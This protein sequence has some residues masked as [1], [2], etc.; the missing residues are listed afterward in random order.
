MEIIDKPSARIIAEILSAH[1]VKTVVCSPGSR[2]VPLLDAVEKCP[3][4]KARVVIDERSAA[5]VALG[6]AATSQEPVALMCTSG[7]ALLNYA[8]AVAEAYYRHIPLIV[9]SA[10]RPQEWIDQDDSQTLRQYEALSNITKKSYDIPEDF[11]KP[12][13][14]GYVNRMVNDAMITAL[15][16]PHG[17]V[18]INVQFDAPLNSMTCSPLPPE[19]TRIIRGSYP[20]NHLP[21]DN[22]KEYA[23]ECK[24]K[25][26]MLVCGFLPPDHKLTEGVTALSRCP[27][28]TVMAETISNL[29]IAPENFMV[30]S[31]LSILTEEEK[32]RLHPDIVITLG[33]ALISRFLKD[34]LRKYKPGENWYV[35]RQATTADCFLSL[36]RR[37]ECNPTWFLKR[38]AGK[39]RNNEGVYAE[40]W[41]KIRE[42]AGRSQKDFISQLDFSD[43]KA[44]KCIF[45]HLPSEFNL[46]LSNGTP[47]RYHQLLA[48]RLPHAVFCNRGV[49]GIDGTI[50]TA[51]GG[52]FAYPG[53]TLLVTGDMSLAYD[54]GALS[55]PGIDGRMK[56]IVINNGGGGIFHFV[57]S[58]RDLSLKEKYLTFP[59][60]IDFR[61]VGEA[62]GFRYFRAD[63]NTE[64]FPALL[65]KFFAD[66]E[67]PY[68]MEIV[69]DGADSAKQ[70]ISYMQRTP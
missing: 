70:L 11:K 66:S 13:Y 62:F 33:G 34:Y 17:P 12:T 30:D 9:V 16:A 18:H 57:A 29:H 41:R 45:D 1:G 14:F 39:L 21:P 6:I 20:E 58:T 61:A 27:N 8:P 42:K 59:T 10:D 36:T 26:I 49:S 4:L 43:F 50:A 44:L 56:I 25:K 69:T 24:G 64:S 53:K 37:I 28:V 52:S 32:E 40:E 48:S 15:S 63:K 67:S 7:T 35:G 51:I 46:H 55:I 47:I 5:F 23:E 2:N 65:K 54:I 38:L 22:L 60:G 3:S 68:L 19:A 31:V